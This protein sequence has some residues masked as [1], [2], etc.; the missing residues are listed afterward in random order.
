MKT[1]QLQEVLAWIKST[2]LV[3]VAYRDGQKGF[4]FAVADAAAQPAYTAPACR[5]DPLVSPGVG[6]FRAAP[7]GKGRR[8]EEGVVVVGG[9]V[10]GLVDSGNGKTQPIAAP[11]A[12]RLAKIFVEDG[13][14]VEYGQLLMF[15][16]PR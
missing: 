8:A 6:L 7:L 13:A 14:P 3:E 12:G 1:D 10:L 16:E 11:R 5:F 4:S 15:L 9:D 2:D